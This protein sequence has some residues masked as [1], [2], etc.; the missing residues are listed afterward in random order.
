MYKKILISLLIFFAFFIGTKTEAQSEAKIYF[1]YGNGCPHCAKEEV[2]LDELLEKPEFKDRVE[3]ISYEVWNNQENAQ[4]LS[5]VGKEMGM[6]T[7]GVPVTV[8]GDK[9]YIGFLSA[10]TTGAKIENTIRE[11]LET[12]CSDQVGAI[13][14]GKSIKEAQN[15]EKEEESSNKINIPILG[16]VDIKS[17]SLPVLTV[18]LAALDGFNPCAMWVLL[19]LIS[20]LLNMKDRRKMWI[21]GVAFIFTSALVYFL[22]LTAWLNLFL[23]VGFL[24][25]VRLLVAVVAIF[26]GAYHIRDYFKNPEGTC[27]VT[28]TKKKKLTFSRLKNIINQDKF[29]LSL[30]GVVVLAAAVNLVELLCSAGLP[31]VYTQ[32]LALSNL[33]SW[34]YY[35]YLLLYVI[36]FMIDDLIIFIIAMK[37]LKMTKIKGKY[38]R[39]T[40][41]V[42]GVLMLIIGLL[43]IFKPGWL[44]FG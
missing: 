10:E 30:L 7:S 21:L 39:I 5:K 41:L 36:I 15:C 20:L 3:I 31:A 42:G 1:F 2:F 40:A 43:L 14:E 35:G 37:T 18:L 24:L 19:F 28:G 38:S 17:L 12:G 26:G 22:F 29:W 44:M 25:W 16:T 9:Y 27:K 6:K 34:E 32:V 11:A 23:F 4:L 8:I 33:P 13:I